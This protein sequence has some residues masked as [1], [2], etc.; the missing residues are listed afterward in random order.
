MSKDKDVKFIDD[1][2]TC[3]IPKKDSCPELYRLVTKY[4]MHKCSNYCKRKRKFSS[5]TFITKCKLGFPHP[6]SDKTIINNV[7]ESMKTEKKIYHVKRD[8][9]E[10]RIIMITILAFC[11][12]RPK[13][14][15]A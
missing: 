12:Y 1:R 5:N 14:I 3:N 4:K 13:L 8:E 9:E 15:L 2:I 6:S 10:V 11:Y 7:K